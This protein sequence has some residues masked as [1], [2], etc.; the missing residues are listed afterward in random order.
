[1]LW[2]NQISI[3]TILCVLSK[4]DVILNRGKGYIEVTEEK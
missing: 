2:K 3:A 4:T 1:M